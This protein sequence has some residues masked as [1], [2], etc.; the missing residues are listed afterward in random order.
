VGTIQGRADRREK[1]EPLTDPQI[2]HAL[3]YITLLYHEQIR[4]P[5]PFELGL[6]LKRRF[7]PQRDR[8]YN[9]RFGDGVRREPPRQDSGLMTPTWTVS[10][11][12]LLFWCPGEAGG[13]R[14]KSDLLLPGMLAGDE[15][16]ALRL[17]ELWDGYRAVLALGA[18]RG[19][20]RF[21]T[22][23]SGPSDGEARRLD[24]GSVEG[25]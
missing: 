3:Q 21:G 11:G 16:V 23:S 2:Q 15:N 17:S 22:A 7:L 14:K 12:S 20:T 13:G 24:L 25:S 9:L 6:V 5:S 4:Q 19:E 1:D 18:L 10:G 8:G